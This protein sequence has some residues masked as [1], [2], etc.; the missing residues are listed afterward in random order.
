MKSLKENNDMYVAKCPAGKVQAAQ[1]GVLDKRTSNNWNKR[2][3][4]IEK[5]D[6]DQEIAD[7]DWCNSNCTCRIG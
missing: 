3:L 7:S 4:K 6:E 2:D 5:L 1:I